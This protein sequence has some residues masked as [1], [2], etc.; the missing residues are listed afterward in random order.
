MNYW[1]VS[2]PKECRIVCLPEN[3]E[4][5]IKEMILKDPASDAD[6]YTATQLTSDFMRF[7]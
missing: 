4:L 5:A 3:I 7:A 2:G 6:D 1:F